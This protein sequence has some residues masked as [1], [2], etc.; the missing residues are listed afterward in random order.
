MTNHDNHQ[1]QP[2]QEIILKKDQQEQ[3]ASAFAFEQLDLKTLGLDQN[4]FAEVMSV[5]KEL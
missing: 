4:D 5:H 2:N 3:T 1:D